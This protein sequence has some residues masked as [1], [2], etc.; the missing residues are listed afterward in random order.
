M[1]AEEIAREIAEKQGWTDDTLL[2]LLFEYI[3]NQQSDDVFGDF[4]QQRAD[5][6]N[7]EAGG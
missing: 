3:D 6:E 7:T 2:T 1:A 4:L 5:D